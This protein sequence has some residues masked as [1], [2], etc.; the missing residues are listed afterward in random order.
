MNDLQKAADSPLVILFARIILP[1]VLT[2]GTPIV[3]WMV[4]RAVSTVDAQSVKLDNLKD[5]LS[6][7]TNSLDLIKSK[8]D[9]FQRGTISQTTEVR[10][11]LNDHETRIRTLERP[12]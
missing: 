5:G 7:H 12:H 11:I 4:M 6:L 8:L 10:A 2:V 1:L 9:D 3:G